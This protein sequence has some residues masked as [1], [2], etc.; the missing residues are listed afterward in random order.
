MIVHCSAF[1]RPADVHPLRLPPRTR[2][3]RSIVD[4]ASWAEDD[5]RARSV[6]ASS[7]QQRLVRCADLRAVLMRLGKVH[8]RGLIMSTLDD[9]AGGTHSLPELDFSRLCRRAGLPPP[10]SQSRRR[11]RNGRV[12]WLDVSWEKFGLVVEIV[13]RWHM[14]VRA[15]WDDLAR[16][17]SLVP[18]GA[19]LLRY[20]SYL[21]RE[22][23]ELVAQQ[24]RSALI[25]LGWQA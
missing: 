12:R 9:V 7:V 25:S 10:T 3:T 16:A 22:Q 15:W 11:D 13:G 1:L 8:R 20:P 5:D 14:E 23:P 6:L 21:V 19:R 2:L 4:A 18:D 24:V 17:N